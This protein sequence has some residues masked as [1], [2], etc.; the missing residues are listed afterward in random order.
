MDNRG[1]SGVVGGLQ[2]WDVD[3]VAAHGGCGDEGAVALFLEPF[4]GGP[5]AVVDA[6]EV[7]VDDF[8]VVFVLGVGVRVWPQKTSGND[9]GFLTP[10]SPLLRMAPLT[11]GMPALATKM[12]RRP[13][14]SSAIRS[15]WAVTSAWSVTSTL[16]A[17]PAGGRAE[18][19]Y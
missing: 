18:E 12:S 7:G 15:T 13:P 19:R 8:M 4:S 2:L 17:L 10:S 11:H 16:Y 5:G 14:N 3:D 9:G 6:V 1:F